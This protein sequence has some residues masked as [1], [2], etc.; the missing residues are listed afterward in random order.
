MC[1]LSWLMLLFIVRTSHQ[2]NSPISPRSNYSHSFELKTNVAYLWWTVNETSQEIIFE[3]HVNTTGWIALGISP[4]GGMTGA[5]IGIGW[6]ASTGTVVF[7]VRSALKVICER[8][9]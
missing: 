4:S 7:Q 1:H 2:A 8:K 9:H 6:V 3:L 5:D